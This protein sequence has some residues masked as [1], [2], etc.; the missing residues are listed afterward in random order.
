VSVATVALL[1]VGFI[2]M[3]FLSIQGELHPTL[4]SEPFAVSGDRIQSRD[5]I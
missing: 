4:P 2:L 3:F 5:R 1:L